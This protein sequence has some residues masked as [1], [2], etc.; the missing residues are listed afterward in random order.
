[1]VLLAGSGGAWTLLRARAVTVRNEL[2]VDLNLMLPDGAMVR[3]PARTRTSVSIPRTARRLA[4]DAVDRSDFRFAMAA[5]E[6]LGDSLRLGLRSDS[7]MITVRDLQ[8]P[9]FAPIVTN[10]GRDALDAMVNVGLRD[11]AGAPQEASCSCQIQP[12]VEDQFI[13]YYRAFANS[14]VR[15]ASSNRRGVTFENVAAESSP[16]SGAFALRIGD[17]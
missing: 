15:L 13:G 16:R 12:N 9:V 2:Y 7:L 5:D 6:P 14:N 1:M 17:R 4:W 10:R 3:V 11:A 8:T